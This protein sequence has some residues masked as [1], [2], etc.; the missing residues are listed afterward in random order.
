MKGSA[1][2]QDL[3]LGLDP[4]E[5]ARAGGL[6]PDPWQIRFLRSLAPR[7]LLNCSRQAG[8]STMAATLAVHT[9]LY[10]PS[11]LVLLLSPSLRQ[12]QELFK[13]AL[14]AYRQMDGPVP[15][16]TESALRLEL[17]NGSRIVSLPGKQDTVRGFSG[18][19]LLV[20][21]EASRVPGD[22]YFA[23]RPMLAVSGGRLLALSTPFGT[24]GWWYEAWRSDEPWERYE[25]PATQCPR[26]TRAFLEE[27]K[28][29]M[30]EWW[31]AQE[32]ECQFLDAETQP[33]GRE[34]I[35]RAFE[36]EVEAWDL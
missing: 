25:V 30:G 2:A 17:E 36:E 16:R 33:F 27:E 5:M 24:R 3:L 28:R 1:L 35:E 34:D 9:A 11:S 22:L 18:V 7:V 31:F 26:I 15:S 32:Y 8:K 14:A 10:E 13:K 23:I 19:R 12:S 21:D 4:V 6:D 29:A 20:V